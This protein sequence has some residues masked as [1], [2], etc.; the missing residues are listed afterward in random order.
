MNKPLRVL[1]VEDSDDDAKFVI[2]ALRHG[3][4]EICSERV[5]T[6]DAMQAALRKGKWDVVLS[7]YAMPHFGGPAALELRNQLGC[8]IPFLIVS[9]KIGEEKAVELMRAGAC[10]YILKDNL[11]RLVPAVERELAVAQ[12]RREHKQL[13]E[14]YRQAQK[15][16]ALGQLAGGVAHDFNNLLTIINGFSELVL[17]SLKPDDPARNFIAQVRKAGERSASLT[18]QLLIFSRKQVPALQMLDLNGIIGEAEK[19]LTRTIGENVKL[20]TDLSAQLRIV[21]ADPG[22]IDQVLFNLLLNARDAMPQGGQITIRT[23][24]MTFAEAYSQPLPEMPLGN[25]VLLEI[26]DTGTGMTP[27]VRSHLFEPFFTTKEVGKGTGLGLATVFGI[28]KQA[29]G[30]IAVESSPGTGTTFRIYFPEATQLPSQTRDIAP[31]NVE[32]VARGHE[33]VLLAED[34]ENVRNLINRVLVSNGYTV[35]EAE[36]G[37]EALKTA[38]KYT[39]PIHMLLS[40]VI[41]P[42]MGGFELAR[43][44]RMSH[45]ETKILFMSGYPNSSDLRQEASMTEVGFLPKPLHAAQ[46]ISKVRSILDTPGAKP[47]VSSHNGKQGP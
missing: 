2:R 43:H 29:G 37:K 22:Q 31:S 23:R 13:E 9:G 38:Q 3:G 12:E 8:D 1:H 36:N 11:S 32:P 18:R 4:F 21:M 45:P 6:P 44:I 34:D 28:V 35:L 7:D 40:D 5:D 33:V 42:E 27:E 47:A 41:M 16:E 26:S 17:N 19:M 25:Y 39:A 14:Q 30:Q 15:M 20:T 24:N 46:L 10:D